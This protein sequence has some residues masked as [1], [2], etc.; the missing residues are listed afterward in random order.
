MV[1]GFGWLLVLLG[2]AYLIAPKTAYVLFRTRGQWRQDP[3]DPGE[4]PM[5]PPHTVLRWVGLALL[6]GGII[7]ALVGS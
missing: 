5:G 2:A 1:T 4:Q 7:L 3:F 6:L